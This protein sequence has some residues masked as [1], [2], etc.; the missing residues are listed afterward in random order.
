MLVISDMLPKLK[1]LYFSD[2]NIRLI[3]YISV[4]LSPTVQHPLQFLVHRTKIDNQLILKCKNAYNTTQADFQ[5]I[6]IQTQKR[7]RIGWKQYRL[8]SQNKE[9]KWNGETCASAAG[10]N[11]DAEKDRSK[12]ND[13]FG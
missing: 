2:T 9:E 1:C 6:P 10:A 4:K 11:V 7:N 5:R 13:G 12:R 3:T 8:V